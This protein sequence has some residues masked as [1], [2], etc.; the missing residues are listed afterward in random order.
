[1]VTVDLGSAVGISSNALRGC[2][3]NNT[4]VV[5]DGQ[6][7]VCSKVSQFEVKMLIQNTILWLDI[8]SKK[9]KHF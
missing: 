8:P 7:L 4:R 2:P 6:N 3:Q 5:R 9:K 1:M